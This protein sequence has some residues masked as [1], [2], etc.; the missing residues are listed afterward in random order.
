MIWFRFL[1]G[2]IIVV[3]FLIVVAALHDDWRD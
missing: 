2:L 3:C 1:L